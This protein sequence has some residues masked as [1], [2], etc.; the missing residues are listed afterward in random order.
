[1]N[2]VKVGMHLRQSVK[3]TMIVGK[4]LGFQFGAMIEKPNFNSLSSS[5]LLNY[6]R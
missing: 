6:D 5:N 4:F 2:H 1:M 3:I